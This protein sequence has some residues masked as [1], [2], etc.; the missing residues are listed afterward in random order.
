TLLIEELYQ[1]YLGRTA[2]TGGLDNDLAALAAGATTD[3]VKLG[4]LGSD[5]YFARAGGTMNGFIAALYRDVLGRS[6]SASEIQGW[7]QTA[8]AGLS[9]STLASLF[10]GSAEANQ[11]LVQ[12]Y[13]Q[14]YLHR[15]ADVA[16]L[17]AFVQAL[18]NGATEEAVIGAIT[19]S[20]EY[21][22][23]ATT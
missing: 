9:R 12:S 23:Q 19:A 5:E 8:A 15:S 20:D 13:Y 17:A 14:K 10:I 4:I 21:F 6:G 1:D 16:G 2:D 11:L 18:Q 3:Q 22:A 7:I